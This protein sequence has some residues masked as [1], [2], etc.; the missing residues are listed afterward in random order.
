M[1]MSGVV[2]K[3]L[4]RKFWWN[5]FKLKQETLQLVINF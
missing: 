2:Y 1:P 3:E 5:N 4:K